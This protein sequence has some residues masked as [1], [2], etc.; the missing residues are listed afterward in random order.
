MAY[1]T[2]TELTLLSGTSLSTAIQDAI[3]AQSDREIK[4][5][6]QKAGL[7]PPASDDYLKTAAMKL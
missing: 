7:T 6:I 5:R 4:A 2:H 3:I 1:C